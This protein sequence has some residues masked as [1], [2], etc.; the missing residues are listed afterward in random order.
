MH[1]HHVNLLAVLV[2]AISTMIVGFLS[3]SPILFAKPWMR[4]IGYNAFEDKARIKEMQK[5]ARPA[6]ARFLRCQPD[7]RIRAGLVLPLA[8]GQRYPLWTDHF[9]PRLARLRRHRTIH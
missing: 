8:S 3:Y 7:L 6:Y 1:L 2:A 4:E 5:S 9:F